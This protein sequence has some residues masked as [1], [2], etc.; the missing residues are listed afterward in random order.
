MS[1]P[2][3]KSLSGCLRQEQRLLK[4]AV[5]EIFGHCVEEEE[6]KACFEHVQTAMT[7]SRY[8]SQMTSSQVQRV[9]V[10]AYNLHPLPCSSPTLLISTPHSHRFRHGSHSASSA[11][12][13][14]TFQPT[15]QS[16]LVFGTIGPA[17]S[18]HGGKQVAVPENK[19]T[20]KRS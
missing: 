15:S 6:G 11:W 13:E 9:E 16:V 7:P 4:W 10:S 1:G 5:S 20:S 14:L 19:A 8:L 18:D 2:N 12:S 17:P 3:L